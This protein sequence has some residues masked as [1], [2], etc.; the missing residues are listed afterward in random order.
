MKHQINK[1]SLA[2]LVLL[3]ASASVVNA[4]S[5]PAYNKGDWVIGLNATRVLVDED[6][7]SASAG[8]APVPNADL[9]IKDATTVSLDASYFLSNKV[10][11]NV[12]GG[13]PAS[14]DLR[15]E[16]SLSGLF[17]GQTDYGPLIVSLQYHVLTGKKFS[18]Y[19]GAGAGR[20][21]FLNEEDR[22]LTNFDIK[23]TWAPAVQAGFRWKMDNNWSANFDVRYTPF[24]VDITGNLGPDPVKAKVKIDPTI[25]G[26]GVA[27][28]F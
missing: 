15:G 4:Q 21:I 2:A 12:F 19:F 5:G 13:I 1:A 20:V 26:I 14:A 10:A 8:G 25:L 16:G 9:S 7:R 11:L 17:L 28:Q 23:D 18:P 24:K 3:S 6:L 27:Y 22:T